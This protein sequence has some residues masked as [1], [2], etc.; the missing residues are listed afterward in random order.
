M[1]I[2]RIGVIIPYRG[3]G[4][5]IFHIPLLKSLFNHY[6]KKLF[7]LTNKSNKAKDLLKNESYIEKIVYIN[8]DRENLLKNSFL[9]YGSINNFNFDLCIT[10]APSKRLL[11]PV[12]LSN[13]KNKVFFKKNSINNLSKYL[14]KES[15]NRFL[16]LKIIK[17]YSLNIKAT[18]KKN[19]KKNIFISIDSHHDQNNWEEENYILLI[20]KINKLNSFRKIY[21]NFAPNKLYKFKKILNHFENKKNI[22]F[23]YNYSFKKV[24]KTILKSKYLI[25]NESG[26]TCIGASFK[27]ETISMY[28]P[29]HTPNLSSKIIYNKIKYINTSKYKTYEIIKKIVFYIK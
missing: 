28:N 16:K 29:K 3:I 24:L 5:L 21:I 6:G 25:G 1:A 17:N 22:F 18:I 11:I 14:I 23:T 8:F 26:P 2:K 20:N 7:L 9:L 19:L 27:K 12:L 13:A 10:T 15:K 4:D